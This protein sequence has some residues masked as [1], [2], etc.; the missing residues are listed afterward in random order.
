M[1]GLA[2][3]HVRPKSQK[4]GAFVPIFLAERIFKETFH[5]VIFVKN[6]N[7]FRDAMGKWG[8]GE[9]CFLNRRK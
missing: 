7:K 8:E 2:P 6:T 9:Q 4:K 5:F 3:N 1:S